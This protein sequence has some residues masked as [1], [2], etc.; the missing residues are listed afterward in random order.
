MELP[1]IDYYL[2]N[3][4]M[5]C[6]PHKR[7][8]RGRLNTQKWADKVVA[9]TE[10]WPDEI[11]MHNA[12]LRDQDDNLIENEISIKVIDIPEVYKY[13]SPISLKFF[14]TLSKVENIELFSN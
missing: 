5:Q 3:R 1:K 10:L 4:R 2:F 7:L 6:S 12:L 13:D 8:N 14:D 11:Q 9:S